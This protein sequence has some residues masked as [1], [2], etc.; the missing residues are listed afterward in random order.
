MGAAVQYNGCNG[1][2]RAGTVSGE[3]PHNWIN[4]PPT[5]RFPSYALEKCVLPQSGELGSANESIFLQLEPDVWG[6]R[7]CTLG[8][9]FGPYNCAATFSLGISSNIQAAP[10]GGDREIVK[11]V[12]S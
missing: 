3:D 12:K 10:G 11:T 8:M 7:L 1:A 9:I 4:T 5:Y 6:T 2:R